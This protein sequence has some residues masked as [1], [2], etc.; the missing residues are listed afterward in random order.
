MSHVGKMNRGKRWYALRD[1]EGKLPESLNENQ[2]MDVDYYLKFKDAK[3]EDIEKLKIEQKGL[4]NKDIYSK[5]TDFT[6]SAVAP[7]AKA[8]AKGA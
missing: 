6:L 2:V 3:V 4:S 8:P 7:K 5:S 1:L